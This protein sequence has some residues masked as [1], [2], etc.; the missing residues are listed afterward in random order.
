MDSADREIDR[1]KH[2]PGPRGRCVPRAAARDGVGIQ[3]PSTLVD[4]FPDGADVSWIVNQLELF[5]SSVAALEVVYGVKQLGVFT[6]CARDRA[7]AAHVLRMSP[8]GVVPSAIA[9]GD[10]RGPHGP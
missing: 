8:S 2:A 3:P 6:Q 7:Q 9:I 1:R 10:E 5:G 4:D